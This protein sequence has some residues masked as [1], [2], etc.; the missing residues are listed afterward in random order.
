MATLAKW[1]LVGRLHESNHPLWSSFVWRNELAD[2]FVE[3][4]AAP[5]FA[6]PACGTWALN[7][8]LR[9]MGARIG[10]GVWCDTYWLPEADL[11]RLWDGATVNRGCV[12][13]T[14]LFHDRM[15]SM[16]SVTLQH[17]G[18][19]GAKQCDPPSRRAGQALDRGSRLARD[20]RRVGARQDPMDRQSHRTVG[21][22]R[23]VSQ[24]AL[25]VEADD[26]LP[27]HGDHSFGV[28]RYDLAIDYRV[29]GNRLTGRAEIA[30]VA[31]ERLR[32]IALDL[33]D[34]SVTKVTVDG[35]PPAK[36][37][38]RRGRLDIQLAAP[39]EAGRELA[40]IV[41]YSGNPRPHREHPSA[42][43]DGRSSPTG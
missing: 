29:E 5:W 28:R 7:V 26:Y 39:V 14:H 35:K 27:G 15:L 41:A 3:V 20:A 23:R 4:V 37:S 30:A 32:A 10:K 31:H 2:T 13:Q 21:G 34:L 12:V 33:Q 19:A 36:Y 16:D 25:L 6:R 38:H 17:R 18:D 1:L 42:R 43:P 24:T 9:S 11:I 8:W 40:V 22:A